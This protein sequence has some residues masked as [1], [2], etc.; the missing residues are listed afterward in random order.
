MNDKHLKTNRSRMIFCIFMA[1]ILVGC[2]AGGKIEHAQNITEDNAQQDK[3]RL[4][5]GSEELHDTTPK[6]SID[7]PDHLP[8]EPLSCTTSTQCHDPYKPVCS[9]HTCVPCDDKYNLC[10]FGVCTKDGSCGECVVNHDCEPKETNGKE[11]YV[12]GD[13]VWEYVDTYKGPTNKYVCRNNQCVACDITNCRGACI[14]GLCIDSIELLCA[15]G[16]CGEYSPVDFNTIDEGTVALRDSIEFLHIDVGDI[17]NNEKPP[18]VQSYSVDAHVNGMYATVSTEFVIYNDNYR[19]M[20]GELVFPL[21][22]DAVVSGYA[23]DIGGMM[24]DAQVVEKNLARIAYE[25]EM[26]VKIDPGL[27]EHVKGNVY[28][29][30]IYPIPAMSGRRVRVDYLTPLLIA[31]NGDAALPLPMP[32]ER[33]QW[34]DVTVSVRAQGMPDPAIGG[35]GQR[36][37]MKSDADW[38]AE[39]HDYDVTPAENILIAIPNIPDTIVS[40]ETFDNERYFMASIKTTTKAYTR[41]MPKNFRLIWDASG[42][43]SSD[44]IAKALKFIELLPESATYELHVFRNVTEPAKT[45]TGRAKLLEYLEGLPY[46]GG[47]DFKPLKKIASNHFDGITLFFTDGMDTMSGAL[48]NFGIH[49]VAVITGAARDVS[50]MRK[51][52][53]GRTLNLDVVNG[54]DALQYILKTPTTITALNGSGISNVEGINMLS[55]GRVT[56]IGRLNASSST[57]TAILSDGQ[58]IDLKI[59]SDTT[60]GETLA[61]AW[62]AKRIDKL[63]PL[64]E[65]NRD[66]LLALGKKF[67]IVSPVTSLI[68]FENLDQWLTYEIEPPMNSPFH[69]DWVEARKLAV[70]SE[71]QEKSDDDNDE[72]AWFEDLTKKMD[73][74]LAWYQ[75]P[76]VSVK[77]RKGMKLPEHIWFD[78]VEEDNDES[79]EDEEKEDNIDWGDY[80]WDKSKNKSKSKAK[81]HNDDEDD[82]WDDDD[83]DDEDSFKASAINPFRSSTNQD[84]VQYCES[85]IWKA[86]DMAMLNINMKVYSR[87]PEVGFGAAGYGPGSTGGALGSKGSS[88]PKYSSSGSNSSSREV[89]RESSRSSGFTIEPDGLIAYEAPDPEDLMP[90]IE[91]QEWDPEAS[92]LQV[93]QDAFKKYK[94]SDDLYKEY[95]KQRKIYANS[96]SFYFDCANLFFKEKYNKLA[97]RI[98]SNLSELMNDDVELLRIYAW[99]LRE[100]GDYDTAI[101]L[102][103]KV[104]LLRPEESIALRDLAVTLTMRAKKNQNP[105][106][107]QEALKLYYDVFITSWY[108]KSYRNA[109]DLINLAVIALEEFNELSSWC[110][111]QGWA[112]SKVKIPKIPSKFKK[113]FESNLRIVVTWD[114]DQKEVD[115]MI[116]EP[117]GEQIFDGHNCS[118]TGG[119]LS[120][121]MQEGYG[122]EEYIHKYAPKGKY[123]VYAR[124]FDSNAQTIVGPATLTITF[125]SNWGRSNQ[126]SQTITYRLEKSEFDET[127]EIKIGEF[128][129]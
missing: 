87:S 8:T 19:Q 10:L 103:R 96:P 89:G 75:Y 27:V 113:N 59:P 104:S 84:L 58:K 107:A 3:Q 108:D 61:T 93:M 85:L 98:L 47:T 35:I 43:R 13:Q 117:S 66:E 121:H 17:S 18:Y 74:R 70:N 63:S 40:T 62:A 49:S 116:Q 94:S 111:R 5:T 80:D 71:Q 1:G 95:L 115:L 102:L 110:K 44:D 128:V 90:E 88:S 30:R 92:Y 54:T 109:D 120:E 48:P 56:V 6:L 123:T 101:R 122:P 86:F 26:K 37:F 105:K 82:D 126:K 114:S 9:N 118:Y 4:T 72:D 91:I 124:Y 25:N 119:I 28:R 55:P 97:I 112:G 68:V 21:P 16:K 81:K 23:I 78:V 15:K 53:S 100:L 77:P 38:V 79:I 127:K 52:C 33:Q 14:D 22:D 51:I 12:T 31:P 41:S 83:W 7:E 60:D 45:I 36:W 50:A 125:Y 46:D 34:R 11:E 69:D 65:D 24:M 57:A 73:M 76:K 32:K 64:P 39:L 42:S 99:R 106:D 129:L 20:E 67:S 29:T 2:Q